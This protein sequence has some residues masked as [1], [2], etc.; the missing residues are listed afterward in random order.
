MALD[1]YFFVSKSA[2]NTIPGSVLRRYSFTPTNAI[3]LLIHSV[4][5]ENT[6][7]ILL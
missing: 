7:E 6:I 1:E 4:K 5:S 2:S 3:P